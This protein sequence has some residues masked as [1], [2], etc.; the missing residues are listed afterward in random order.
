M[1]KRNINRAISIILLAGSIFYLIPKTVM[2]LDWL[3]SGVI[4]GYFYMLAPINLLIIIIAIVS[5]LSFKKNISKSMSKWLLI[6]NITGLI[7]MIFWIPFV[8]NS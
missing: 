2:M 4:S 8:F 1:T 5:A 6:N 3:K 7:I